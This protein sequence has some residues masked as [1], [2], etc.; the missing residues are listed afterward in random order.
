MYQGR[1]G[2]KHTRNVCTGG[3]LQT[4]PGNMVKTNTIRIRY[5]SFQRLQAH[6]EDPEKSISPND[7]I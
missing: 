4:Q 5:H 2:C 6:P 3:G 7:G 1:A